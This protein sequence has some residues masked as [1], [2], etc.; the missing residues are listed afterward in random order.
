MVS[1][2]IRTR[3]VINARRAFL[4]TTGIQLVENKRQSPLYLAASCNV[5]DPDNALI[6]CIRWRPAATTA[7][8]MT[9]TTLRTNPS[10]YETFPD[11]QKS[12]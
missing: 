4:G 7:A 3:P 8:I 10:L 6:V 12:R 1:I 11:Q 5:C 2:R 9:K